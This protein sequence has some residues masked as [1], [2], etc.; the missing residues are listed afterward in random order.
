MKWLTY[1]IMAVILTGLAIISYNEQ[2][3]GEVMVAISCG[4]WCIACFYFE[5][6]RDLW[7]SRAYLA[8]SEVIL[9]KSK[10]TSET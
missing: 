3:W 5:R 7:R 9:L 4:L 10:A 8:A 6:S 2:Q 1:K